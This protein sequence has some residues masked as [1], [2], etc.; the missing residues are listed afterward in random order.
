VES[1]CS[2]Q[3][4]A[5]G[6]RV[7]VLCATLLEAQPVI[8]GLDERRQS[9][10]ATKPVIV[11]ELTA[12]PSAPGLSHRVVVAVS[13]CDKA[14]AAHAVTC[15]LQAMDPP[16]LMVLQV[17]IAG[18]LPAPGARQA[19]GSLGSAGPGDL[20]IATKEIY[21]DTG[22]SSPTG[23]LSADELGLPLGGLPG[24]EFGSIFTLDEE[25]VKAVRGLL[26][27]AALPGS[28]A[29]GEPA[30][31]GAAVPGAA[32]AAP[33]EAGP[34][35]VTG[36]CVTVSRISGLQSEGEELAFRWEAVAESME[37]AAAAHVCALY[38]VPF[39]ELRGISNMVVDR[40]RGSWKV[41]AAVSVAGEAALHVC[42]N[43]ESLPLRA[44]EG[45][46]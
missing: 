16:P 29:S 38:G 3:E 42:R 11:G 35:V 27:S 30:L 34:R 15:L 2:L 43:L 46:A 1:C 19:G 33:G 13:G 10:V 6:C 20:V 41:E 24:Q 44:R 32:K 39:L 21:A 7:V 12:G 14:N 45:G 40:D 37:G 36:P 17:G 9:V 25:L 22:S 26:E 8:D 5:T 28:A 23:W 4:F 31:P 18:A